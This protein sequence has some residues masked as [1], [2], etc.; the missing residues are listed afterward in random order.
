MNVGLEDGVGRVDEGRYA[1]ELPPL[2]WTLPQPFDSAIGD[3]LKIHVPEPSAD[4]ATGS[5]VASLPRPFNLPSI[6]SL[7]NPRVFCLARVDL[8]ALQ[9]VRRTA[10]APIVISGALDHAGRRLTVV[11]GGADGRNDEGDA[12]LRLSNVSYIAMENLHCRNA[13]PHGINIDDGG[14]YATP[15]HHVVLRNLYIGDVGLFR[16]DGEGTNSDCL[17]LSGVDD[18]YVF[19]SEFHP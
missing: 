10:S 2:Q 14:D 4:R 8:G 13:F 6:S 19:G 7:L 17:M 1:G 5:A 9:D 18:F 16:R 3:W 12:R 11:D 15:M